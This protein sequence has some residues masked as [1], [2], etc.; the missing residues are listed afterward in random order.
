M[1]VIEENQRVWAERWQSAIDGSAMSRRRRQQG[2]SM[3]RWNRM[4][5]GFAK[6]T[7]DKDNEDKRLKTVAWLQELGA[8]TGDTR[9]L[10]IGAG[11]G[12]W[13]LLL[14]EIGAHVT[15]LEPSDGMAD[16][17]QKRMEE[18]GIDNI[19][20]DRRTWQEIDLVGEQWTGSFDLV[21]ASMTPGIDGP[22][23]LAKMMAASRG[24][25]Y[26][27][28]FSGRH[29]QQWYGELWRSVFNENL[30]GHANDIINPF[31]LVYAMGYR[32]EL[33]FDFW[34]RATNWP[35]QKAIEDCYTHLEMYTE[36]TEEIKVLVARYVDDHCQDGIF[37][38]IRSGCRGMMVWDMNK[39]IQH[40][41]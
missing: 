10:D 9:V 29:W 14:A 41:S 4:A 2:T 12:N 3:Q 5:E 27:S 39:R 30:D 36:L 37:S 33:R 35:R 7:A 13:S 11:P 16:I 34:D 21:F 25:C 40:L 8:L 20:I 23:S 38:Q 31:N 26:L 28:A 1:K 18:K 22:E 32:P 15:A 17:L 24:F 19:A 6:R